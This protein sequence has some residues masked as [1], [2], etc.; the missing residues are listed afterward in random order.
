MDLL[1]LARSYLEAEGYDVGPRGRDI[2]VG[3][4][5]SLAG[6]RQFFYAA[7]PDLSGGISFRSQEGPLL[8]RLKDINDQHP[9]AQKVVLVPSREGLSR[10]FL[11]GAP[12]WYNA[13][14]RVPVQF[15]DT[16]FRWEETP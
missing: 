12:Q 16:A 14:V 11:H 1:A 13:T 2:L 3:S 4:K 5:A 8:A 7:V 9:S 10:E 6:E 15:F